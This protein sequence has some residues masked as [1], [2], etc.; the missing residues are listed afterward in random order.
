MNFA[1]HACQPVRLTDKFAQ[2][3]D[4]WNPR[5]IAEFNG[6]EVRVARMVGEFTWHSHADSD[7]L[8]LV[9]EGVL[10]MV[11]RDRVISLHPGELIVVPRGVEHRPRAT[12]E[13]LALILDRAGEPNTGDRPS[14][15][16]RPP[17]EW[18]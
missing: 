12:Q 14:H 18:I 9:V 7:E 11:F 10:E 16:T 4:H 6:Q 8:F 15:L 3:V 17:L 13:C 5:I 1:Q 2:L